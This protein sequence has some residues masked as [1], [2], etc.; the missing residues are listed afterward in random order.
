M[1]IFVL[2]YYGCRQSFC[3]QFYWFW[4]QCV[5]YVSLNL[6]NIFFSFRSDEIIG[7]KYVAL[8]LDFYNF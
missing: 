1:Y 6:M 3:L 2:F 4:V 8:Y 7:Y 5:V